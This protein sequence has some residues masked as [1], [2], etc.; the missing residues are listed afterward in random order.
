MSQENS[1]SSADALRSPAS[2]GDIAPNSDAKNL[3]VIFTICSLFFGPVSPLVAYLTSGEKP[4]LKKQMTELLNFEI[5]VMIV[6][7]TA[8]LLESTVILA[9]VGVPLM[10]IVLIGNLVCIILGAL[11]ASKGEFKKYPFT[12]RLLS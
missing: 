8:M 4:W 3:A 2:S 9:V 10:V 5:S 6:F 1:L 11:K 12:L 7:I